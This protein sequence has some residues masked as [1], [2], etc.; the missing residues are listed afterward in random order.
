MKTKTLIVVLLIIL[1]QYVSLS[2]APNN[3]ANHPPDPGVVAAFDE[4]QQFIT[5]LPNNVLNKGLRNSLTKKLRNAEKAYNKGRPCTAANIL[6]AYLNQTQAL[7]KGKRREIAEELRNLGWMVRHGLLASLPEGMSCP[8][9]PQSG[10]EPT[11][12]IINSN[13]EQL[14]GTFALSEPIMLTVEGDGETFTQVQFPGLETG[15][16]AEGFAEVGLPGVQIY[17][18]LIAVPIGAQ[19]VLHVSNIQT[20]VVEGVNLYPLQLSAVD[21]YPPDETFM[22]PPFIKDE[23]AYA[24]DALFPS[25]IVSL[26]V[27]GQMRDLNIV[28]LNIASAQYN[29]AQQTLFITKAVEV[30]VEYQGGTGN[31]LTSRSTNPFES[32]NARP[33]V[34]RSLLNGALIYEHIE[35]GPILWFDFG[36]ELL[37][38]TDP[39]FLAAANDLKD[40]KKD[41]GISTKVFKTGTPASGGIGTTED[42][43][44]DFIQ[45]R[46][47]N[48]L[49]RPSYVLLLGDAEFIPPFYRSSS[50]SAT[51]GTDLDYSLMTG[52]D[53]LADLGVARIPV[54]T[55]QQA[56]DVVD[57]IINYE[58]NPPFDFSF[59]N[60]ASFPAYFQCCRSGFSAGTTGR[61]YIETMEL[62]RDALVADGYGVDRLYFSD[63]TYTNYGGDTTPRRYYDGTALPAAI[64]PTSG[65]QWDADTQDII[66]SINDGRFLVIHRNHGGQNLWVFPEFETADVANL[67]NGNLLP[68]LFSVDCATGLFDNETAAGDYGTTFGG[69]YLLE[70][71]LRKADGGV[72]GALG[73]TRDSPTWANNALTR[74]FADAVF[75]DVLPAY[76]GAAPIRR[77]A[78]ILNYGKLYMFDEMGT[79]QTAGT[80]SYHNASSNNV[81]WHAFGDPTQEIWTSSPHP[82][83]MKLVTMELYS[84]YLRVLY[85]EEGAVITAMQGDTPIG[86]GI[87]I[88]GEAV[89]EYVVEPDSGLPITLSASK[90]N[91]ISTRLVTCYPDLPS[92]VLVCAGSEDYTGSDGNEYTRYF[93]EVTNSGDFPN[94]LFLPSPHLPPCGL[95]ANASRSWVN[96]YDNNDDR[97]YG[98]CA[99]G[100]SDGLKNLW[101]AKPK[102]VA[103]PPSVYITIV[104][105]ECND[106]TYTS[107]DVSCIGSGK[108]DL[109]VSE[110]T[111]DTTTVTEGGTLGFS[112]T[113]T[114][115]GGEGPAGNS[116]FD[117]AAYLSTDAV[118]DGSDTMVLGLGGSSGSYSVWTYHLDV[119]WSNSLYVNNGVIEASPGRY[120]LIVD[121][122]TLPGQP[123]NYYPGVVESDET[124]NWT[125]SA[126]FTVTAVP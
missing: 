96:I 102:G 61:A 62:I 76:G 20:S 84:T 93:L 37:I 87:V 17:H 124:N 52:S 86:R 110:V 24:E 45:D 51:T 60:N 82:F 14:V 7:R 27:V 122:D 1:L 34:E 113:I 66:D 99:L 33:L 65:F 58:K 95:N 28:Q 46:Y 41:K 90:E 18:R 47:D 22:D 56:Q 3:K 6:R 15:P 5:E 98:F 35:V 57:K 119:G 109:I 70:A 89:L 80:I 68:V 29:P 79:A 97:I 107:N 85:P 25:E 63:T 69:V 21:D 9:H 42:E 101:F 54:D 59:Y 121:A 72:V 123:P 92:P 11:V 49:I 19:A 67:N 125:A 16:A 91:Y 108:P 48:N 120:Y 106:T 8:G 117:V 77:L 88:N 10:T 118:L 55:A 43:I 83:F 71:M 23:D 44:K 126:A 38:I 31:F 81:M 115:I 78:D 26:Q 105:R 111:L 73:D 114:N 4:L 53:L 94:A 2:A 40:W 100:S 74:G 75:P 103:P 30:E 13:N 64:G 32:H 104:D 36:E 50:G 116:T 12:E 112:Y 39:L